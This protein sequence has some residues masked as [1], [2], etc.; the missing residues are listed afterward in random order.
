MITGT[1]VLQLVADGTLTLDDPVGE[2][3][4]NHVGVD[5]AGR[6]PEAITVRQLLSHTSGFSEFYDTFFSRRVESCRE[7]AARGLDAGV[8]FD[9]G[10]TYEYSQMNF[11]LLSLLIEI[12][13]GKPYETVVQERLLTPLGINGMRLAGTFDPNPDEVVHPSSPNRNYME[14]LEGAG[15]WV[16]TPTDVVKIV[17][18]LD[19]TNSGIPPVAGRSRPA[20]AQAGR[21][22]RLQ[23]HRRSDGTGWRRW[24]MP[25]SRG[26][27][28]GRSRTRTR[29]SSIAPTG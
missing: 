28:P 5:V 26:G 6:P 9:P 4:G 10:T 7:A 18:S 19:N 13:T 21:R 11:C 2:L 24:H 3:L 15:S 29:W 20:D 14:V 22:D 17:D 12:V 27:T 8:Q 23:R 1:V 16:A 25:T